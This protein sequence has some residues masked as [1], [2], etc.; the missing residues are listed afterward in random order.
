MS[1]K[2]PYGRFA[3]GKSQSGVMLIVPSHGIAARGLTEAPEPSRRPARATLGCGDPRFAGAA[4][5]AQGKARPPADGRG[6]DGTTVRERRAH[7]EEMYRPMTSTVIS[8]ASVSKL[9]QAGFSTAI[10][11]SPASVPAQRTLKQL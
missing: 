2:T 7:N 4:R 10:H 1:R 3:R 11:A 9:R 8:P 5:A 6:F